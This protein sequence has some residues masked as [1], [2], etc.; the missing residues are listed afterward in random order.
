MTIMKK[1]SLFRPLVLV[2]FLWCTV[3]A[4]AQEAY[5][6]YTPNNSTLTFYYDNDR[7]SRPGT[8]YDL[9][10]GSEEPGWHSDGTY[11]NVTRVVF[12]SSFVRAVP[13]STHMWFGGMN[14]LRYISGID[15]LN[16]SE[17]T[18]M[19]WM[20]AGCSAMDEIDMNFSTE[21]VTNM[22]HMFSECSRVGD[23]ELLGFDTSNVT[24]M[25]NMFAF[26]TNLIT[27]DLSSFYTTQVANMD[28]M[29]YFCNNI[30]SIYVN[31]GWRT[32][33]VTSSRDMFYYCINLS[34]EFGT[35]FNSSH[36]DAS[37]A[38]V[39]GGDDYP[40][41]F[42]MM[43][44]FSQA[45]DTES[46]WLNYLS[47]CDYPW[48]VVEDDG[49]LFARSGN[50]GLPNTTSVLTATA[51]AANGDFISFNFKACNVDFE[52]GS[53]TFSIN[54]HEAF[55]FAEYYVEDFPNDEWDNFIMPLPEGECAF[56]WKYTKD[57]SMDQYFDYFAIDDVFIYNNNTPGDVNKDGL[58]NTADVSA[59]IN[60]LLTG[61][62][63]PE[64]ADFNQDGLVNTKD[65]VDLI[66]Y[67]LSY[68]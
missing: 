41:Y 45:L 64:S 7:S 52:H 19:S 67:L 20:F 24:D 25:S 9:N 23:L 57:G 49:R 53:C 30:C 44:S 54:G 50:D 11:A 15:Y 31:G 56:E 36:V 3:G 42:S 65:I 55:D 16:T 61:D 34:G 21:N 43:Y 63:A 68:R 38:H 8:T 46:G 26:C 48:F 14:N 27:L 22:S 47:R 32:V 39:D 33:S 12:D 13:T 40:G 58:V 37:Y 59:M 51:S 17:V 29:F 28:S 18:D 60:L 2:M 62:E 4:V 6:V 10:T 5:A 1:L 66:Q 35:F